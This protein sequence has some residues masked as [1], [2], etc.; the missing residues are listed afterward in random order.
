MTWDEFKTA[1]EEY[2]KAIKEVEPGI[3]VVR[4]AFWA[5]EWAERLFAE[6]DTTK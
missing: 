1:K 4:L 3:R 2:Q 5:R 6:I